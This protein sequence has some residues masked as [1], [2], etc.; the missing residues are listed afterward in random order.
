MRAVLGAVFVI[1]FA[2]GVMAKYDRQFNFSEEKFE[3]FMGEMCLPPLLE[4]FDYW[5]GEKIYEDQ[6]P[7][8]D[9]E[10]VEWVEVINLWHPEELSTY[11]IFVN[12]LR[13][14][15][16]KG[17]F[18]FEGLSFNLEELGYEFEAGNFDR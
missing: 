10:V 6:I 14:T 2:T 18:S 12:R 11:H 5:T 4:I 16:G 15:P 17:K 3:D 1:L 7:L 8:S 13:Q 9:W